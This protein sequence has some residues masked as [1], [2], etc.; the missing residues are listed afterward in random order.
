MRKVSHLIEVADSVISAYWRTENETDVNYLFESGPEV[1]RV[2]CV[3]GKIFREVAKNA[4]QIDD[5]ENIEDKLSS[6]EASKIA[7]SGLSAL[8]QFLGCSCMITALCS[9]VCV[10]Q[11]K[12]MNIGIFIQHK[13]KKEESNML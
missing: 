2:T 8:D 10:S 13:S 7:F 3:I 4:T 12:I 9:N 11:E 6:F 5:D 1:F